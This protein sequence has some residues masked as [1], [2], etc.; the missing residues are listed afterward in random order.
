MKKEWWSK[1]NTPCRLIL[2]SYMYFFAWKNK[3]MKVRSEVEVQGSLMGG[4]GLITDSCSFLFGVSGFLVAQLSVFHR[5]SSDSAVPSWPN[6]YCGVSI[7]D[8]FGKCQVNNSHQNNVC[9]FHLTLVIFL[10]LYHTGNSRRGGD[11]WLTWTKRCHCE[12]SLNW[13]HLNDQFSDKW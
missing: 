2:Q 5:S 1:R 3:R 11:S 6:V 12:C 4:G 8:T 9:L 13:F 10:N 7:S